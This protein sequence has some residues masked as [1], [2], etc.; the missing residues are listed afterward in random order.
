M[1]Y[2][3]TRV[4][5]DA[6]SHIMELPDFLTSHADPAIRPLLPPIDFGAGDATARNRLHELS[7][8]GRGH[9]QVAQLV[10]LGDTLISGPKGHEALG[11]FDHAERKTALDML[12]FRQQLVFST[13]STSVVF[14]QSLAPDIAYGAA[15]A[16]NHAVAAFCG[17]DKRLLGAAAIPLDDPARAMVEL[18]HALKLGLGGVWV[19]H[20]HAGGRSPG[21]NDFDPFWARLAEA[22]IPF[23]LHVGGAALHIGEAWINT[24]RPV[25][26]DWLGGG[27]NIRGKDMLMLHHEPE[28]FIGSMVL[29]GVLERHPSLRG[30]IIEL[31]AGWVPAMLRRLDQ[32]VEI[33]KK[34]E[35]ELRALSRKPSE[36]I[37]A[38]LRFTPFVFEDVGAM[39]AESNDKLYLFSSDYPHPE[40][41][42]NPLGRFE[43]S[44]KNASEETLTRFYAKN[45]L[46]LYPDRAA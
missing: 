16:H 45:F 14:Q 32:V 29:D 27:E 30:G 34:S 41:G 33:W 43:A 4:L 25:P 46:D 1:T 15:R 24:G 20:R 36:Q 8:A 21:H 17:N 6:D 31:G 9:A 38:Q 39:I 37:S 23:L 42:R 2:A 10:A 11:A 18:E 3:Q 40:G 35:P 7:H 22:G 12:G 19:P 26:T 5:Y 13:F 44:L 28:L